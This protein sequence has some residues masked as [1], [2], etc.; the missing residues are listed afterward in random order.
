MTRA[1]E[2]WL[3]PPQSLPI[4]T[5]SSSIIRIS[6]TLNLADPFFYISRPI[7]LLLGVKLFWRLLCVN[8]I[9]TGHNN[10]FQ[11]TLLGW[12][13]GGVVGDID[14]GHS[15]SED[16]D[17]VKRLPHDIECEQNFL[18]MELGLS[19]QLAIKRF[20]ALERRL[21]RDPVIKRKYIEFMQEYLAL[22]H[23]EPVSQA[24]TNYIKQITISGHSMFARGSKD[25]ERYPKAQLAILNDFY[26]NDLL[27][28]AHT[29]EE[30]LAQQIREILS[31]AFQLHKGFKQSVDNIIIEYKRCSRF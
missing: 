22:G 25:E 17:L 29:V 26:V 3:E 19:E 2:A 6:D 21:S 18:S 27:T 9:Q 8:Q 23:M 4:A 15:G 10:V 31:G 7:D 5:L 30:A 1:P 24:E 20:H 14:G 12:V 16:L 28:G 13:A 11:K